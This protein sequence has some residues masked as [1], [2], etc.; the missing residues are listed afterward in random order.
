MMV[1]SLALHGTGRL[2][3]AASDGCQAPV[4]A[5]MLSAGYGQAGSAAEWLQAKTVVV[6]TPGDEILNGLAHPAASLYERPFSLEGARREHQAFICLM[7][8]RGVQVLR[9]TDILLAGTLDANGRPLPGKHLEQLQALARDALRYK[10]EKLPKKLAA[11]Q[12][13]YKRQVVAALHP[14]ELVT[15]IL[16]QPTVILQST[17]GHNTGLKADYAQNPLM[18]LYFM[19]DQVITTAKG[20]VVGHFNAPQRELETKI[21]RFAYAKIGVNPVYAVTGSARLEGGDF[22]PA[23]DTALIGQGLRTN[24]EAIRQ[25]LQ[26]RVFG[27][28]RVA[29][30][31]DSWKNQDQMHLDTYFNIID[32]DLAV[33]VEE[34]V[35][36]RDA[37]GR[38]VKP[39]D[40]AKRSL[41]DVY[42]LKDGTYV[43]T[44]SNIPFQR[45]V[46]Q[47]LKMRLI[48]VSNA[49]QLKYGINFLA[50][51][52]RQILA[53]D[54]VSDAYKKRLADAGVDAVWMDFH[55]LTGGYGAAHCTTQAIRRDVVPKQ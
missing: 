46:E 39:A 24:P 30:V 15:I 23:G 7:K 35:D 1:F 26:N 10:T 41:V 13:S 40:P 18:N 52:G 16:Q 54:G 53:I 42:E 33:I 34:R 3:T 19:R 31:K 47:D 36:Q 5:E 49:D 29:V 12:E 22:I 38:V 25:L 11:G 8:E 45:F 20:M 28:S 48:P 51:K 21:V 44:A 55:N 2:A 50:V 27:T 4:T 32:K 6:H 9:L 14:R 17:G 37:S 43:K